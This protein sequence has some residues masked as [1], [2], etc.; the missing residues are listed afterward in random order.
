MSVIMTS[1]NLCVLR[2]KLT[3]TTD[4]T[5]YNICRLDTNCVHMTLS[6]GEI[7]AKRN[8]RAIFYK[9]II[10]RGSN[11]SPN[12][13]TWSYCAISCVHSVLTTWS[14]VRTDFRGLDNYVVTSIKYN[15]RTHVIHGD[16]RQPPAAWCVCTTQICYSMGTLITNTTVIRE[17]ACRRLI[18]WTTRRW[19][20]LDSY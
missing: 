16:K 2:S 7:N 4:D 15:Q 3:Y 19:L 12:P 20:H 9:A 18:N 8:S 14:H 6:N 1:F 11:A 10:S 13:E 17:F 5:V